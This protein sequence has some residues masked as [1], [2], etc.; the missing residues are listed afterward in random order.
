MQTTAEELRARIALIVRNVKEGQAG[1]W[2]R[3]GLDAEARARCLRDA[4]A[5]I[6][7]YRAE[8]RQMGC[9]APRPVLPLLKYASRAFN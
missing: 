2:D 9:R 7:R 8:L 5:A 3:A 6:E 4:G 1:Q